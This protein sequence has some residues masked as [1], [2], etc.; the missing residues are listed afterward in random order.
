MVLYG[1]GLALSDTI[2]QNTGFITIKSI[3]FLLN[4]IVL[5]IVI[6]T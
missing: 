6:P 4:T 3:S 1:L 2:P 5:K